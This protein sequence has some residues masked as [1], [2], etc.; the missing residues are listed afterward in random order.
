MENMQKQVVMAHSEGL[1]ALAQ[2]DWE[3]LWKTFMKIAGLRP[4]ILI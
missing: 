2:R 3:K 1:S 4:E